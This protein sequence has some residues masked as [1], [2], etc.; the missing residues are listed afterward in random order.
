MP[1]GSAAMGSVLPREN[2]GVDAVP[3]RMLTQ[4]TASRC[5]W[6]LALFASRDPCSARTA[7]SSMNTVLTAASPDVFRNARLLGPLDL[8]FAILIRDTPSQAMQY[9]HRLIYH[10]RGTFFGSGTTAGACDIRP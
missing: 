1:K 6:T 10:V 5:N 7:P 9:Q 8:S 2:S 3:C 4:S